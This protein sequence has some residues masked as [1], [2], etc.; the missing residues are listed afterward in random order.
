MKVH[1][2]ITSLSTTRRSDSRNANPDVLCIRPLNNGEPNENGNFEVEV[3]G[4]RTKVEA[5]LKRNGYDH[6]SYDTIEL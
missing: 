4:P 3:S 6:G 1:V 2:D 5:W